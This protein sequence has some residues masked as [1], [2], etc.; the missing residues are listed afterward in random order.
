L[1]APLIPDIACVAAPEIALWRSCRVLS[2]IGWSQRPAHRLVSLH[3]SRLLMRKETG[4]L[5]GSRNVGYLA[6]RKPHISVIR[7]KWHLSANQTGVADLVAIYPHDAIETPVL[8]IMCSH[9][10]NT[11][12]GSR[13]SIYIVDVY[14]GDIHRTVEVIPA[15][16]IASAPPGTKDFVG[17]KR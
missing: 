1:I 12:P 4:I 14:V 10:T 11:V 6:V 3:R 9:P 5:T 16:I 2:P 15:A 7:R 17:S 13:I 8:E